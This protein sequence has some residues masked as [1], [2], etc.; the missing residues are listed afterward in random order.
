MGWVSRFDS[1]LEKQAIFPILDKVGK[2]SILVAVVGTAVSY[3]SDRDNLLKSKQ[4][5]AWQVLNT[6][7]GQTGSG[8]RELAIVDLIDSG[9]SMD[10]VN[11]ESAWLQYAD[12]SG[13]DFNHSNFSSTKL[14]GVEFHGAN[15]SF[16]NFQSGVLID[17]DFSGASLE[18]AN[19][20]QAEVFR[21]NLA[22]ADVKGASF[23]AVKGLLCEDVIKAKNWKE[24]EWGEA[25]VCQ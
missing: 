12:F 16:A 4:F 15:L 2:C 6:A 1:W 22:G 21:I 25:V 7:A 23:L 17:V 11:L 18:G 8:G 14:A 5:Q 24:A 3:Q 13:G 10:G 20:M 19:F 9:V